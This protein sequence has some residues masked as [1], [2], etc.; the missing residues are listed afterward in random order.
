M[1]D[2]LKP[3]VIFGLG[4]LA[5]LAHFYFQHDTRRTVAGFTI[6][7]EYLTKD[8]HRDRPVCAFD[9]VA[10]RFPAAE[11]DMFLPISFKR[12]NR[13][14]Q[15]R[16]AQA[17]AM[18]YTCAS[19][20]S[21]KATTW[22]DLAIGENCFIFEDNTIQ[23]FVRI[24]DN[25]VLWSGNHV[26]HHTIIGDHVFVTSHVV[27]S[28]ACTI[29][30]RCFLGVNATIRDE[31]TIAPETLI[32]MGAVITMDTQ[33]GDVWLAAKSAKRTT[34]SDTLKTLSHKSGG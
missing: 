13:L 32:G 31:T 1:T 10:E 20:V 2:H 28:G 26:G 21:S 5:D 11:Y 19:Y 29:G 22:P 30:D 25:C 6:D 8:T 27:I 7:R 24:G 3:I 4:Q 9:D 14:R 34:K 33:K 12:M 16:F 15:E 17:K 23:P 18:G